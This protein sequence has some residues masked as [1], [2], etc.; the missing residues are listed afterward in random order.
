MTT[1]HSNA[2][3]QPVIGW[4]DE[5]AGEG[6]VGP[7][8]RCTGWAL[9]SSGI[10]AVEI[11]LDGHAF[12]A[13]IGIRRT[14]AAEAYPG[15][16]DNAYGGFE[17]AG[18]V[19][20]HPA[21]PGIDRRRLSII[22]IARDGGEMLL[23][24]RTLVEPHVHGRWRC[25]SRDA[26]PFF[27][28][29]ALSGIATGGSNGLDTRYAAYTSASTRI[30]MRVPILYL[31]TTAGA[32]GD[33]HFDPDFDVARRASG[34][35]VVDD[36]L[37]Q[38]L[39]DSI[40]KRLPVLVTLNGGI[41]A[42]AAGTVPEWDLIDRLEQDVANCQWNE[43]DEVMPDAYLTNLPGSQSAPELARA[44][45]LNVYA[46][47][48][49]RCKKRNLQ[50]A[51]QRIAVFMRAHPDLFIGISLDPDVYI[52]PFFA[53]AQWYDYNPGTLRQFRQWLAVSGPYAGTVEAGVPELARYRRANPLSLH[54]VNAIAGQ[55]WATWDDV[56]P[57][58]RFGRDGPRPFWREPWVHEWEM[59]RRHI[60][61]LHY[62]E[63]AQWSVEA[64]LPAER[65]WSSQGLMAPAE[66]CMPLALTLASP[67]KNYDS[68]GVS[69]EGS[70]PRDGHLGAIVY[71]EAATND[72]A[73][74]NGAT[75]FDTLAAIDPDFAIVE[76]N[77]AD[78]RHPERQPTYAHAYRA[79]R[80]AW[81]AGARLV[82]PMAWNGSSGT[83]PTLPG[84]SSYTAWRNT[85]LE[86]AALD[87]LLAR[88]GLPLGSRLWTF[89]SD[90]HVD[91]DGWHVETGSMQAGRGELALAS[92]TNG[93]VALVSPSGLALARTSISALVVGLPAN[94][95]LA[96]IDVAGRAVARD[97]WEP[98]AQ[99]AGQALEVVEAGRLMKCAVA[100]GDPIDQLR[101]TVTLGRNERVSVARIAILRSAAP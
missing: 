77:T 83:D 7:H 35:A 59:F 34:R 50:Q 15:Y 41:W 89:G 27:L 99:C 45:T 12:K 61:R 20:A 9:A 18:N 23:A 5:P 53:E 80:D 58:R 52:N 21:R 79:L 74:E 57:P 64:G 92:A 63:L 26:T 1:L 40:A 55:R 16:P 46:G 70:K 97:E 28:V 24:Q 68:G 42:D 65:I 82:S 78:L 66:G 101:I 10:R 36:A 56:D 71:G 54:D 51:A 37:S 2:A 13:R 76:F 90:V 17:F 67:V 93:I 4:L 100:D 94:V 3:L 60:V 38:V 8:V 73:M 39:A 11:R 19:G 6:I 31:R 32:A 75:L 91:D 84:Y 33:Y 72:I 87:F 49:R 96:K 88:S 29:P 86:A 47:D 48:V 85:P 69:I 22:V 14:D 30:G 62:D 44:L 98:V 81:N 95:K 43:R 25:A